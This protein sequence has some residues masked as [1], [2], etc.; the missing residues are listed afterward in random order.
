MKQNN[1]KEENTAEACATPDE[2]QEVKNEQLPSW[3]A[4]SPLHR[5]ITSH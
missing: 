2:M 4:V 1:E 3:Q 5:I